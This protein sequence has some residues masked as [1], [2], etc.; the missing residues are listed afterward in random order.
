[1][2]RVFLKTIVFLLCLGM[3]MSMCSGCGKTEQSTDDVL[4]IKAEATEIAAPFVTFVADGQEITLED[5]AGKTVAELL[6]RAGIVVNEGDMLAIDPDQILPGN[7]T[8]RVLRKCTVTVAVE[9]EDPAANVQYTVVM[10][11]GTVADALAAVGIELAEHQMVNFEQDKPLEAD[12]VILISNAP[13]VE[14][15]TEPTEPTEPE[16]EEDYD[17]DYED[18]EPDYTPEVTTPPATTP[19]ATT[20]PATTPPAPTAPPTTAPT[21]PPR[22]VVSVQEYLDCDGS[23]HGVR[24]ITYSDG[25]Q[26]EEYF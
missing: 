10:V 8:V 1:M 16:E 23:G 7:I 13:V 14:E 18:Y 4:P 6:E 22:T 5:T 2:K 17:D 19:S 26:E 25:T 15:E 24:V 21:T 11:G 9:T 20:P 12:M 3:I